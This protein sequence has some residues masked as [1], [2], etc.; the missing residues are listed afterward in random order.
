MTDAAMT[1]P[2]TFRDWIGKSETASDTLSPMPAIALAATLDRSAPAVGEPLPPLWHWIY[3]LPIAATAGLGPDGHPPRGDFLP[4]V[5]LPRRMWAG[6]RLRFHRPLRIGESATRLSRI[7]NVVNKQGRGGAL[8]VVTVCH[9]IR[10]EFGLAITEEQDLVYREAPGPAAPQ[11]ASGRAPAEHGPAHA[12]RQWSHQMTVDPVLLFRY[13]AVTF[14]SHRIHYDAPYATDVEGYPAL[15]VHGPLILTLL[16]DRLL[17][18]RPQTTVT[19]LTARALQ[20]LFEGSPF[21]LEG[22]VSDDGRGALLWTVDAGGTVTMRATAE[23]T[24]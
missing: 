18:R 8:V 2:E 1:T 12:E 3:F 4:P 16:L 23:L 10:G 19:S 13:S 5:P 22:T 7:E 20:P 6:S 24:R 14:N 11:T 9:E 21:A 17:Q 15:V